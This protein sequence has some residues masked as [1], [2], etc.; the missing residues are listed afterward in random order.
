MQAVEGPGLQT[1]ATGTGGSGQPI[2]RVVGGGHGWGSQEQLLFAHGYVGVLGSLPDITPH[3]NRYASPLAVWTQFLILL[4]NKEP[5]KFTCR[6][7][8]PGLDVSCH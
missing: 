8:S 3:S 4:G 5:A 7:L 6:F 1:S 2:S